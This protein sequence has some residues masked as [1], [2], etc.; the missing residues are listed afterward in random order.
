MQ[1]KS[2]SPSP[3]RSTSCHSDFVMDEHIYSFKFIV[4]GDSCVGKSCL[5]ER[6]SKNRF[7]T[8]HTVTLGVQFAS[9]VI[10]VD[11]HVPVKL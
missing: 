5:L 8:Q 3:P 9:K 1:E 6:F 2:L 7:D 4:V 10:H 11:Q